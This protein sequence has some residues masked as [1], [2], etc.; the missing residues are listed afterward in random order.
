MKWIR[1]KN[2]NKIIFSKLQK[3]NKN[4]IN[5]YNKNIKIVNLI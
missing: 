5:K 4:K 1:E 2:N 3:L